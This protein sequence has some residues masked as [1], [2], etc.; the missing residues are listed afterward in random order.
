MVTDHFLLPMQLS[1]GKEAEKLKKKKLALPLGGSSVCFSSFEIKSKN[2]SKQRHNKFLS[3][4][5]LNSQSLNN[6]EKS[7]LESLVNNITKKP[8]SFLGLNDKKYHLLGIINATTD[9]FSSDKKHFSISESIEKAIKLWEEGASIIDVGG[10]SSRP[11][12]K[13]IGPEL[14]QKRVIPIIK[15]L[16]KHNLL[17]S[18]DTRHSSTMAKA[19]DA[20]AKIINDI[21]ALSDKNAAKIISKNK[22]G[23]ILM[24]MQGNP[25]NMQIR[26][27]YKNTNIEILN[28]LEERINYAMISGIKRKNILIDPG[29]GFGK[30]YKHNLEIF[31]QLGIYHNLKTNILLGVSRKSIIE[32][33]TKTKIPQDRISGS[34]AFSIIAALQGVKF[35][36][37]HDVKE[38][39]QT[40]KVLKKLY[41]FTK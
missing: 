31:D 7:Y 9:S 19:I 23:V 8:D 33:I 35:F 18:C 29:I 21:S 17:I 41:N 32:K 10:E 26:P 39:V 13:P 5:K 20:G 16:S 34:L 28:F 4:N 22:V 36:R 3:V 24:H 37:V 15:E 25:K 27:N 30:T 38:T 6:I 11:G 12:A 1:Y 40:L 2:P 14:E